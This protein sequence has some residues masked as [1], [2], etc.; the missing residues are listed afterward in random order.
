MVDKLHQERGPSIHGVSPE[1]LEQARLAHE[2]R[3]QYGIGKTIGTSCHKC[4][5]VTNQ[6]VC[7]FLEEFDVQTVFSKNFKVA[8]GYITVRRCWIISKCN[9]CETANLRIVTSHFGPDG[10]L[11]KALDSYFPRKH[12]TGRAFPVW[13]FHLEDS[14]IELL[15]EIY[16]AVS[17]NSRRLALMGVRA[18]I[19][20]FL[21]EN[22]GD[23]G[24]F[25]DKLDA[26]ME[27]GYI[28]KNQKDI[29]LVAIDAGSAA[30]HRGFKPTSE[31]LNSIID[32]VEHVLSEGFHKKRAEEIKQVTPKRSK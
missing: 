24:T 32:I 3:N 15:T 18:I 26:S 17:G 8:K 4:N 27:A 21:V 28:N 30:S 9:G 1:E 20:M 19:D 11:G 16:A 22:I 14:Y 29:L 23:V 7:F 13:V 6:T 12:G 25:S 5:S 31:D 2:F 10:Q